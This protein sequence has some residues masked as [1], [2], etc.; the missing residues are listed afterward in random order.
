M[1]PAFETSCGYLRSL[2]WG[3]QHFP[4]VKSLSKCL[5]CLLLPRE[6]ISV[7]LL[8]QQAPSLVCKLSSVPFTCPPQQQRLQGRLPRE[9]MQTYGAR[10]TTPVAGGGI[11]RFSYS[12][13]VPAAITHSSHMQMYKPP[14][15]SLKP[16][17]AQK[18]LF[19][20]LK[21]LAAQR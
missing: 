8:D 13:L 11:I 21:R 9:A 10:A 18:T 6:R 19:P 3:K 2:D 5:P 17:V 4:R 20:S 15:C 16:T 7:D 12:S 1:P 14:S